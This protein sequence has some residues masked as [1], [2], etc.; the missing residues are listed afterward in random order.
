MSCPSTAA[1]VE[2]SLHTAPQR[3]VYDFGQMEIWVADQLLTG[4]ALLDDAGWGM[5][6]FQHEAKACGLYPRR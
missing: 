1:P 6:V 2:Y 4:K 5:F 3:V